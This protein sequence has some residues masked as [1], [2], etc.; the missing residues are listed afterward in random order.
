[1]RSFFS[2]FRV[3]IC[4]RLHLTDSSNICSGSASTRTCSA[5]AACPINC[6]GSWGT[7]VNGSQTYSISTSAANGGTA[8]PYSNGTTQSCG[9]AGYWGSWTPASCPTACGQSAS[10]LTRSC[11]GPYGGGAPCVGST[12]YNCSATA[13]CACSAPLTKNVTVACDPIS[14]Y[15]VTGSVTRLNVKT[16]YP[17]CTF[18]DGGWVSDTCV[19]TP[20]TCSAPLTRT[21]SFSCDPISGYSVTGSVIRSQDKS[22]YPSCVFSSPMTASNSTYI[23]DSCVYTPNP[24]NGVC[25]T[26]HNNCVLGTPTNVS[27]TVSAWTWDCYGINGG[28]DTSCSE[29]KSAG[30]LMSG[31]ISAPACSIPAGSSSC[32]TVISWSTNNPVGVSAVTSSYP[33][34]DTHFVPGGEKNT[35]SMTV[36][37]PFSSRSFFLYNSGVELSSTSINASCV[38][39]TFWDTS[40]VPNVC[41]TIPP[42]SPTTTITATPSTIVKGTSSTITWSSGNTTSCAGTGFNTGGGVAGSAIVS[43]TTTTT[44]SMVCAGAGGQAGDQA[45]VTVTVTAK[46][47]MIKEN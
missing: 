38:S 26:S 41:T 17:D 32:N 5:T 25:S 45:T 37:I 15:S 47:P 39:G 9:T 14:G 28:S 1:M 29:T 42:P 2:L 19:Y 24:I 31:L 27:Q 46:K 12:T 35:S 8:C 21:A 16:S 33:L 11:I 40:V 30:F 10:T 7:C 34:P 4:P 3:L 22:A 44:Y 36:S 13:A 20:L 6:V 43:P 18:V 23:S